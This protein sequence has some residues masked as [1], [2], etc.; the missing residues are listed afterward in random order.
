MT[1]FEDSIKLA[2]DMNA[3]L[4]KISTHSRWA[5]NAWAKRTVTD[6]AWFKFVENNITASNDIVKSIGEEILRR[7]KESI[8]E[9]SDASGAVQADFFQLAKLT[10]DWLKEH[11]D[12]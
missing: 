9:I 2:A 11:E 6:L 5:M 12:K 4:E 3:V 7:Q 10:A 1:D 8:E